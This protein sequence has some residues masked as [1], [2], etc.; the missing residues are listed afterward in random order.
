M[1]T[2][3]E[4]KKDTK[5]DTKKDVKK[6]KGGVTQSQQVQVSTQPTK[7]PA[8][9]PVTKLLYA[10]G[11]QFAQAE[12][13]GD[14]MVYG[15]VHK[16]GR[17][18]LHM[19]GLGW[20]LRQPD[21][22]ERGG[23]DYKKLADALKESKA[24]TL[25]K[26]RSAN[27][28]KN[29][30][31]KDVARVAKRDAK[32][33]ERQKLI[34]AAPD[35]GVVATVRVVEQVTGG[36]FNLRELRGDKYYG[37]RLKI[38][39]SIYGAEEVKTSDAGLKGLTKQVES[40]VA[41]YEG[42]DFATKCKNIL[43]AAKL[44][45]KA[46]DKE[47]REAEKRALLATR[48]ARTVPGAIVPPYKR[49]TKKEYEV[50]KE[51]LRKELKGEVVAKKT[52]DVEPSVNT[53]PLPKPGSLYTKATGVVLTDP[54]EAPLA[55]L[56]THQAFSVS[57]PPNPDQVPYFVAKECAL[58]EH[59][60]LGIV[61]LRL[62]KPGL[63]G[64]APCIYNNGRE[65]SLGIVNLETLAKWREIKDADVPTAAR[66]FL[67][68]INPAVVIHPVAA[69][70]LTAVIHCKELIA[71]A[72]TTVSKFAPPAKVAAKKTAKPAKE[73]KAKGERAARISADHGIKPL[74]DPKNEEK[75]PRKGTFCY[76]QAK[77]ALTS[78]TVKAAQEK[79]DN[80]KENPSKGRK[81]EVAWLVKQGFIKV[82]AEA[83]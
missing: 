30:F 57:E 55:T 39:K 19:Y 45:Q 20:Q 59:K 74:V 18:V 12:K 67:Q 81:L 73:K 49:K 7:P 3:T 25:K 82:L 6:V 48:D 70:H 40:I 51:Q 54:D 53:L 42:E 15:Y 46:L 17:A 38:A 34:A 68:P 23:R 65:V 13:D 24:D 56:D 26:K 4:V 27:I 71:M 11:F 64:G 5:K 43:A 52:E 72:T 58:V 36:K 78:K 21:G 9:D 50:E 41:S 31:E 83:A 66:Q 63:Y 75:M 1:K 61:M 60:D 29:K 22:T 10:R 47:F 14:T 2:K 44:A 32:S 79:L 37:A 33:E 28:V 76:A 80:D 77:A 8:D 35:E 62:S 69:S 16:D